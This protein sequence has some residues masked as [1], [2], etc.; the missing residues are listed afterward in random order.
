MKSTFPVSLD[1]FFVHGLG[2]HLSVEIADTGCSRF[3]EERRRI[4]DAFVEAQLGAPEHQGVDSLAHS[5]MRID[6]SLMKARLKQ[7]QT[8]A[9]NR[10]NWTT[11]TSEI[12]P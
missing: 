11:G 8:D 9:F 5:Q 6:G 4:H 10:Q 12:T 1:L 3:L 7:V 2:G